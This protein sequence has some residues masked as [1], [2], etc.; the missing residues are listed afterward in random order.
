M[1]QT[2]DTGFINTTTAGTALITDTYVDKNA[3][4][5]NNESDTT[6]PLVAT[7]GAGETA[8]IFNIKVPERNEVLD[9]NGNVIPDDVTFSGLTFQFDRT[10]QNASTTAITGYLLKDELNLELVTHDTTDGTTAWNPE[11]ANTT[12]GREIY[13]S[14][15]IPAVSLS[16]GTGTADFV[17]QKLD[18]NDI[19]FGSEFQFIL[20]SSVNMT[21]GMMDGAEA[22]RPKIKVF[23]NKPTPEPPTIQ[24]V[25]DAGGINGIIKITPSKDEAVVKHRIDT[26]VDTTTVSTD[27]TDIGRTEIL[28]TEL[29]EDAGTAIYNASGGSEVAYEHLFPLAFDSGNSIDT[30]GNST[31]DTPARTTFRLYAEDNYNT[32]TNGG[33]S[34][35]VTIRRPAITMTDSA[36]GAINIG[37]ENVFTLTTS[38]NATTGAGLGDFE[39]QFTEYAFHPSVDDIV[40]DT[41]ATVASGTLNSSN[42]QHE[43]SSEVPFEIGDLIKIDSE[44][45]RIVGFEGGSSP[46]NRVTFVR[47]A[48]GSTAASHSSGASIFK[49]DDTKFLFTKLTNPTSLHTFSYKYPK[50]KTS[51]TAVAYVKDANGFRS[52]PAHIA[53]NVSES[54]PIAKLSASR[55]K[56]PYAQYGDNVAGLTLS[57]SNSKAIGSDNELTHHL[58]SYRVGKGSNSSTEP[59]PIAC[60]NGLTNDNSCFDSGSKRVAIVNVGAVEDH[61]DAK[62]KI[63]GVASFQADNTSPTSDINTGGTFSHYKYVSETIT[64]NAQRLTETVSTNFYKSIDCIVAVDISSND[65]E[66]TR[67]VLKVANADVETNDVALLNGTVNNATQTN[68]V[69][70]D[71]DT[72]NYDVGDFILVKGSDTSGSDEI[73]QIRTIASSTNLTV[74]RGMMF[75]TP[76]THGNNT[77]VKVINHNMFI[78]RD[79]R[80]AGNES[81]VPTTNDGA[82]WRW[83][84][85]A[86]IVGDSSGDGI[87]FDTDETIELQTVLDANSTGTS[88]LDWYNHGFL[89]GDII[90]VGNTTN[91][92][93]YTAPKYFKI[94]RMFNSGADPLITAARDSIEVADSTDLLTDDEALFITTSIGTQNTDTAADIVRF[95]NAMNPSRTVTLSSFNSSSDTYDGE[96]DDFL[97]AGGV[98]DANNTGTD[99]TA[100]TAP[101]IHRD[102][103]TETIVRGVT[104][105][106]LDLDSLAVSDIAIL[107]TSISR[108]GGINSAMA[109][110]DRKYPIAGFNTK[111]GDITMSANIRILT[112]AGF[113]Q[114]WSLVEGDRYD[115]VFLDSNEIDSP[116]TVYKSYRLKLSSGSINKSPDNAAQY[117][118][119]LSFI[120]VGEEIA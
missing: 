44:Y 119:R 94:M 2:G 104:P 63:F 11:F 31:G 73:M 107:D 86:R 115:F 67:Y 15:I 17:L 5:D 26:S 93:T 84:G 1:G 29:T 114:I 20:Y 62:F 47:G 92:G 72:Q 57:L 99:P 97:F 37:D 79:L 70:D 10:L 59:Q 35:I 24:V 12:G 109:L 3:G 85:F 68:I 80:I 78:N 14:R 88:A 42:I 56:V 74:Y 116:A 81:V 41:G 100:A 55:T 82:Y 71:P 113:R 6:A 66:V 16:S 102:A 77:P 40:A 69:V 19:T 34:N 120:V 76:V 25:P 51:H 13:K 75:S 58:F 23:F 87:D 117:T 32:D 105:R 64:V 21:I 53:V 60:A 101:W 39:G 108:S 33:S 103:Y 48:L 9:S 28:T 43:F 118:A 4:T 95:D 8:A 111:L 46:N 50:A 110:G 91:N 49:V 27:F 52:D 90:K 45:L 61:S 65:V 96:A 18:V 22:D 38:K 30:T 112:Q 106:T 54:N 89:E 7:G 98:I 83:G 36:T